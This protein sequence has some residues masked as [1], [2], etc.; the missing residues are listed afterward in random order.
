M[1]TDL[2]KTHVKLCGLFELTRMW[3]FELEFTKEYKSQSK[4]VFLL[5]RRNHKRP[6]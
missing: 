2:S 3:L 4:I 5:H 1:T 6:G